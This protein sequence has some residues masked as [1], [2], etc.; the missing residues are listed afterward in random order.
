MHSLQSYGEKKPVYDSNAYTYSST[1]HAGTSTLQLYAH[2][3]APT[4][5]EG[6]P[7]YHMTKL[8]GFDLTDS[9]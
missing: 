2:V 4:D 7:G 3:T 9:S 1:Y 6:R 8:R 5:P